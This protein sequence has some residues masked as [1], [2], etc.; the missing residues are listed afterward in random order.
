MPGLWRAELAFCGSVLAF[1]KFE[2]GL[3]IDA[4]RTLAF[5]ALVFGSQAAIYTI[6]QR[7]SLW[8][9]RPSL[10]LAGS[11]LADVTIASAFA[12]T[13]IAMTPL[14]ASVIAATL[15]AAAVFALVL[16]LSKM[17]VVF[18]WLGID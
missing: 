14:P 7:R 5:I 15:A 1:S 4:L 3:R 9:S 10:W 11:S 18:A 17:P 2:M 8:G 16:D 12:A 13:G 6:R